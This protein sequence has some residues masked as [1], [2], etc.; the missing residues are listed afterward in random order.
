MIPFSD[1]IS[2]R[3][4]PIRKTAVGVV[5]AIVAVQVANFLLDPR[6]PAGRFAN[7]V[8][9]ISDAVQDRVLAPRTVA[10]RVGIRDGMRV[11]CV[12]PGEGPLVEALSQIVGP[13]GRI[14]AVVLDRPR[15]AAARAY[16]AAAGV[17]NA[18]I[19]YVKPTDLPYK[20]GQ[21]DAICCQSALG[22]ISDR[23]GALSEIRR[24]LR[25]AGRL[26]TS[27]FLGDP[28]F[29]SRTLSESTIEA[30]GFEILERFGNVLAYTVN[31]RKPLD[32]QPT[33]VS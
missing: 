7:G 6:S 24:V 23:G 20:D 33:V 32:S 18:T 4:F 13:T 28:R 15:I 29:S 30:A 3:V 27:E 12:S 14:E 22:R 17:E 11:L 26:S 10:R 19:A 25:G 8:R 9:Q 31:F 1:G 16:L 2:R 5:G 21:F